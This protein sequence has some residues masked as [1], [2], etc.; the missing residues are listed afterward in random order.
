VEVPEELM[1]ARYRF[2]W[3]AFCKA[4]RVP[5]VEKGP[6]TARGHISAKCPMCGDDPSQHMGMKLDM[7]D[8]RWGCLRNSDHRG[9]SPH[10]L[11]RAFVGCTELEAA[12]IVHQFG[13]KIMLEQPAKS[14]QLP[15]L[16]GSSLVMPGLFFPIA[17]AKNF[18]TMF[19][20]YLRK[21]NF[22]LG[23]IQQVAAKYHLRYCTL[24]EWNMRL[25]MPIYQNNRLVSWTGRTIL[26]G[27]VEP[28]RYKTLSDN[29]EAKPRALMKTTHTLFNY[30]EIV[31]GGRALVI[32]EGPFDA[33][34]VD[35]YGKNRNIRG[36]A[37]FTNTI[38]PEQIKLLIE[39]MQGYDYVFVLL[40]RGAKAQAMKV[41]GELQPYH[42]N[43]LQMDWDGPAKDPGEMD[44]N[45]II[46]LHDQFH[47]YMKNDGK[48][49]GSA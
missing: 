23:H 35:F 49:K 18:G 26:D 9:V 1:K 41:A 8:P 46:H 25:I 27:Q 47:N 29:A 3:E 16:P 34:K 38:S 19:T 17:G 33:M 5:F 31:K 36:T 22:P 28:L 30:D 40:D 4:Y 10:R 13:A 20:D 39:I 11:I 48:E 15:P 2:N 6:N 45:S 7:D 42:P 37:L 44:M 43:V 14:D 32:S 21:R 24:G 12:R